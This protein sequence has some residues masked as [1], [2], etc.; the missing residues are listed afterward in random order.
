[1]T[2][3]RPEHCLAGY[4]AWPSHCRGARQGWRS[5]PD[6]GP[7]ARPCDP[8]LSSLLVGGY[9][10]SV[11]SVKASSSKKHSA[12][13]FAWLWVSRCP[14]RNQHRSQ[15]QAQAQA[16]V[17]AQSVPRSTEIGS[18]EC[19]AWGRRPRGRGRGPCSGRHGESLARAGAEL[20]GLSCVVVLG[21]SCS[22]VVTRCSNVRSKALSLV[23]ETCNLTHSLLYG[24]VIA[25][26][27]TS[28]PE[29]VPRLA[30]GTRSGH[31]SMS[32]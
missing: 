28:G 13:R 15:A 8:I 11:S 9:Q 29:C 19:R 20:L 27:Q 32:P 18:G 30:D 12:P 1:M 14:R 31:E 16:P 5:L 10:L 6:P 26:W 21:S 3:R 17:V 24:V 25:G 4:T 22:S 2:R 7:A 23:S